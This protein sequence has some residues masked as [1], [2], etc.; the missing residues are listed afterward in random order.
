MVASRFEPFTDAAIADPSRIEVHAGD[1]IAALEPWLAA[2][3]AVGVGLLLDDPRPRKGTPLA[4]ALA[5]TDGR[6][7]VVEGPD[8]AATLRRLLDRLDIPVVG[9]EVKPL[10]VARI[11][12]DADAPPTPVAFDTQIAAYVLNAALRSQTIADVVAEQLDLIL[13][14]VVELDS[15]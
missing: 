13:P 8:D 5:G 2:Q 10:L 15:A 9:H 14:P 3:S 1:R 12:D 4:L 7:I 11:A 6:T